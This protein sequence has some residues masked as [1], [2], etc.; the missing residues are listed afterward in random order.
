M[1]WEAAPA[2]VASSLFLRLII[3][4]IPVAM[5]AI[6]RVIIDS[7]YGL[8]SQHRVLPGFF[9]WLV[10]LEFGLASLG[11]ILARLTDF[12]DSV[13]ADKYTRHISTRIMEH[14]SRLDLTRYEDPSFCDKMERARVQGTDRVMMIQMTGRLIQEGITTASLAVGIFLFSPWML[15]FLFVCVVPAFLGETHFAFLGYSM[16]FKQTPARR[17]MEY[18]R[19]LAGSKESAKELKLFRLGPFLVRRYKALSDD[20]HRQTVDLAKRK[21]LFGGLLT[22]LGTLGYYGTYAYVIYETVLG[23]LTLGQLTFLAGAI[24][25]ASSNIQSFFSTFSGIA[26]QSLFM[27]DLLDF[28]SVQPQIKTKPGALVAPR[29]I[30]YGIEFQHV[31]FAYP[32]NRIP[33]L[34]DIDFRL[35]PRERIALVGENGQGKTT[36]A[37]LLTR[38]YDPTEGRILLDGVDLREYDLE[39]WWSEIGV[40]F[41]DFMRYDMTVTE[42]I[43][44]GR[45]NAPINPM[46]IQAA[47]RKSF[48]ESVILK[49]P[50]I[51]DQLL[52]CRFDGGLDL[53]GGEWQKI[54]LAR[55]HL[56]DAQLLILDEPTAALD[57]RSER[58]V[59]ERFGELT[60]EKTTLLISHR[61]STVRMADRIFVLE[62]GKIAEQGSHDQLIS[63]G[64][65]YSEM[66]ELQAAGYR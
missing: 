44:V 50:R 64:G 32:G 53:S 8:T 30:R 26:D 43:A 3:S 58:E 40:I 48:A 42:N 61:F 4:L 22:V 16:N 34:R 29:P 47:A 66:F 18:L 49:L 24:A 5:L 60:K 25:G 57:A 23:A 65:R 1:V 11:T 63:D 19:V 56:R 20:L 55:A 41:Q 7:I 17:Q 21:L 31:S 6:T 51:Y 59:F 36:I 27:T 12:C 28:F 37:K 10:A 13:L 52:G 38:L 2:P 54:A 33:V 39:D 46:Q 15:F 62:G 45:I 14:A 9:W 35:E